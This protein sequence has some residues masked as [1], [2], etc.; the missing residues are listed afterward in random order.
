MKNNKDLGI[1]VT[2]MSNDNETLNATLFAKEYLSHYSYNQVC[3]FTGLYESLSSQNIPVLHLSQAKF[4]YGNLLV[5][6]IENLQLCLDFPNV[7]KILFFANDIP[8]MIQEKNYKDWE[9][10]FYNDKVNIIAKNQMINDI[11]ELCY[12]TPI[13]ISERL[14][15]EDIQEYL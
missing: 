1:I 11:F 6:D 2:S 3:F 13:C 14:S 9:D 10:V 4:F 5:T 7:H 15:Y 12:K 8:W